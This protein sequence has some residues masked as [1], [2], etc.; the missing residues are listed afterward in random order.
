MK[1]KAVNRGLKLFFF[2]SPKIKSCIGRKKEVYGSFLGQNKELSRGCVEESVVV[3]S[4]AGGWKDELFPSKDRHRGEL[5]SAQR[6]PLAMDRPR[7]CRRETSHFVNITATDVVKWFHDVIWTAGAVEVKIILAQCLDILT[8]SHKLFLEKVFWEQLCSTLRR[9]Q[10]L[11]NC[12][13]N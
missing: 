12:R 10:L 13:K 1:Q 7:L 2:F 5:R 11:F 8:W 9:H 4:A 6:C 3:P